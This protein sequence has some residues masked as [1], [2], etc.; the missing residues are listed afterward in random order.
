METFQ[1]QPVSCTQCEG[2]LE[3]Q[4]VQVALWTEQG[5]I[6]VDRVPARICGG[7]SEQYYDDAT[8]SGLR[9]LIIS[10]FPEQFRVGEMTVPLYRLA[11]EGS[12][13]D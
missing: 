5:L 7:C 1:P 4:V 8:V 13:I 2:E 9:R 10:N 12:V 3:D 6:V 11:S